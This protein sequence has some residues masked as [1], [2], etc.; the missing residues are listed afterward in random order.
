MEKFDR[1]MRRRLSAAKEEGDKFV[2]EEL[3]RMMAEFE[4]VKSPMSNNAVNQPQA[5]PQNQQFTEGMTA[6]GPNGEVATFINGQWLV[7]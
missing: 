7:Q 5:A 2:V 4:K 1:A 3:E 6:T